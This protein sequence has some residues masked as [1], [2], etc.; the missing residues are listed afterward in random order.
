MALKTGK[1][2]D[3]FYPLDCSLLLIGMMGCG[4]ST[5]G[6]RFAKCCRMPFVDVDTEVEKAAGCS[7][8]DLFSLY[9]EAEFRRGEERI[10]ERLLNGPKSVIA[11]GGGSF[12]SERTRA[13]SKQ[14]AVSVFLEADMATLVRNTSGRT[15][16]PLLNAENPEERLAMLMQE[17]RPIYE[18]ADLILRYKDENMF[19]LI[20]S[21]MNLLNDYVR[22]NGK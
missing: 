16:R 20:S 12:L 18:Q 1:G 9:G 17:R 5:L 10:M 14:K 6:S 15:H 2:T 13:L 3:L 22:K 21:L 11:A 4:K 19:S 7:V 8:S